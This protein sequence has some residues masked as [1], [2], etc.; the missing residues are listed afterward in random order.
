MQMISYQQIQK[1]HI[2]LKQKSL[3]E[4]KAQIIHSVTYGRT[5]SSK[6][7][8]MQEARYIIQQLSDDED[9]SRMKSKV[10]ALAYEAGIIYGYTAEDKKM[11]AAKIDSFLLDRGTIKK[12][13]NDQSKAELIKTVNQFELIVKHKELAIAAKITDSM[14]NELNIAG[15]R[16]SRSKSL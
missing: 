14:L 16:K 6:E 2:L 13:I 9:L 4:H 10:F 15:S 12:K 3:I 8:T 1:L 5:T 7:L 11:N